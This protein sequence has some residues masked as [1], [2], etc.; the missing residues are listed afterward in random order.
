VF[1][2]LALRLHAGG[3]EW[4]FVPVPGSTSVDVGTGSCH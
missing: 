4:E 3:Y 1:G 2:V